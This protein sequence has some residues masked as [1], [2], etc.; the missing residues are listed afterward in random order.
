MKRNLYVAAGIFFLALAIVGIFLPLLP[1]T[2]FLILTAACFNRGSEKFHKWLL[3]H[4]IFGPP[5]CDWQKAGVIRLKY[6]AFSSLMLMCSGIYIFFKASVPIL[7]L[8][9]YIAFMLCMLVF[10]WT[11]PGRVK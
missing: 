8:I 1:T 9:I 4:K 11:R 10:I 7:G 2:P 5:I 3:G 6:K